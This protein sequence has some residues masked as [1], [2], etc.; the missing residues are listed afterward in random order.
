MQLVFIAGENTEPI[1]GVK[2]TVRDIKGSPLI[3]AVADGPYFF[4]NP[5]SG[6]WTMDAEYGGE[7]VSRR[8]DLIGRRY[9]L[10]EFKFEGE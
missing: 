9:I 2:V 10:L 3:E 4:F 1:R 8:V 7:V 5:P 6:R